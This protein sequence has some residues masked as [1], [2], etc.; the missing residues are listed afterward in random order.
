MMEQVSLGEWNNLW[1]EC[2]GEWLDATGGMKQKI[3]FK[4]R[5]WPY[6]W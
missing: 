1:E 3:D 2:E 6:N 5:S 4:D